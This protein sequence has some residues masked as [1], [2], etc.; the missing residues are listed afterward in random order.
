MIYPNSAIIFDMDGVI[1]DSEKL[2]FDAFFVAADRHEIEVN[3]EFVHQFEG[4]SAPT[5]I[6]ILQNFFQHDYEKTERFLQD[7]G[8]AREQLLAERGLE[9]KEGFLA[10]FDSVKASGRPIGLVTSSNREDMEDNFNRSEPGLLDDFTHVITI[11][12]VKYPK[13]N[14]QPYNMMIRRLERQP[15]ECVVIEDSIPGV[16]AATDAGT[17]TI[18]ISAHAQ[19]DPTLSSK[20]W[21]RSHHH[22][23]IRAFLQEN[24]L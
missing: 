1:F 5:C 2:Y 21:H 7:W 19:P 20:L 24:G 4:K 10:L 15:H 11:D 6:L 22:D 13:P 8:Q 17:Q 16:T 9:F 23:N 3:D 14:P 12:D 18:M